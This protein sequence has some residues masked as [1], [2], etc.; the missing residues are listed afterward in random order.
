MGSLGGV[1]PCR[2]G[3]PPD[4]ALS[5]YVAQ[6]FF[7]DDQVPACPD[8]VPA[9][10][11]ICAKRSSQYLGNA[12]LIRMENIK[13]SYF[14]DLIKPPRLV[15]SPCCRAIGLYSIKIRGFKNIFG[16]CSHFF[17]SFC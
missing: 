8:L 4:L 9:P 16:V 11:K 10:S 5:P 17:A 14:N 12:L 2:S 15:V 6:E 1:I 13:Q 3:P 7:Q